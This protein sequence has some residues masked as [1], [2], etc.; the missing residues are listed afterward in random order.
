MTLNERIAANLKLYRNAQNLTQEQLAQRSGLSRGYIG[1]IERGQ[2]NIT[3]D[4]VG[5]LADGL[6]VDAYQLAVEPESS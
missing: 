2:V 5:M 4:A 6:G 1:K 3:I